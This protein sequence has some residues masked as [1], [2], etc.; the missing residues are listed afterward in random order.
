MNDLPKVITDSCFYYLLM[1]SILFSHFNF[2][3]FEE[4]ITTCIWYFEYLV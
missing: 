1:T 4:N 3:G 2:K